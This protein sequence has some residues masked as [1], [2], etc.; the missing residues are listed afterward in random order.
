MAINALYNSETLKEV[1]EFR[2]SKGLPPIKKEEKSCLN[3]NRKFI[4]FGV[5]Q[6]LCPSCRDRK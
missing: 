3:C 6:R 2:K 5:H 4:G 1:N